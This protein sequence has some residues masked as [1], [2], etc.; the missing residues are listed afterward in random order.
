[1]HY[2]TGFHRRAFLIHFS[3]AGQSLSQAATAPGRIIKE[4]FEGRKIF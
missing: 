2:E 1:M 4:I 3:R